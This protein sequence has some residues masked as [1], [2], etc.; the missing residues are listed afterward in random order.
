VVSAHKG[1]EH[2]AIMVF[3]LSEAEMLHQYYD[4][5][6]LGRELYGLYLFILLVYSL[7]IKLFKRFP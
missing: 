6:C 4:L 7:L 3:S 1:A 5:L 2:S